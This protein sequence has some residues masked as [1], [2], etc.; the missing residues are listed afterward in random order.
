MYARYIRIVSAYMY[1][2]SSWHIRLREAIIYIVCVLQIALG[3][4][5]VMNIELLVSTIE[6]HHEVH[7][8]VP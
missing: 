1:H 2:I 6:R 5:G 8:L 7:L 3:L 4:M